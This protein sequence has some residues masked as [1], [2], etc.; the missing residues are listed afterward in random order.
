MS[1]FVHTTFQPFT[2]P[3]AK[4]HNISLYLGVYQAV[5][6]IRMKMSTL[7]CR[8]WDWAYTTIKVL[9][10]W[11]PEHPLMDLTFGLEPSLEINFLNKKE[12]FLKLGVL[13]LGD[14]VVP[15]L[16][17]LQSPHLGPILSIE[18]NS[19]DLKLISPS[20]RISRFMKFP[21]VLDPSVNPT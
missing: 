9:K 5:V 2:C 19:L 11:G 3:D 14:K 1:R 16:R 18:H 21:F 8:R 15:H 10:S 13:R 12:C 6:T 20:I 17:L 7:A 4:D